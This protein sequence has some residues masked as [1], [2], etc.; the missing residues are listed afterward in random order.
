RASLPKAEDVALRDLTDLFE[1][2]LVQTTGIVRFV[3]TTGAQPMLELSA[4]RPVIVKMLNPE[5]LPHEKLL[6]ARIRVRGVLTYEAEPTSSSYT[7]HL[8]MTDAS[9]IEVIEDARTAIPQAASV[10]ALVTDPKWMASGRRVRVRA[11]VVAQEG[12]RALLVE[13]GGLS[14]ILETRQASE[15]AKGEIVE[16][17]GWPVRGVGVIRLTRVTLEPSLEP[18]DE[19]AAD[20]SLPLLTSIADI[21]KL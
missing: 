12:E 13:S 17:T 6:D 20:E 19:G 4:N 7:P 16:A 2:H 14:I 21:R 3:D 8:W 9:S 10:R 5:K 15:F 1:H 11:R 18:L